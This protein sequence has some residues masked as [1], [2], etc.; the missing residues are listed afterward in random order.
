M[1]IKHTNQNDQLNKTPR[2]TEYGIVKL[3]RIQMLTIC[4]G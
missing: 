3:V 4:S 1:G 2:C